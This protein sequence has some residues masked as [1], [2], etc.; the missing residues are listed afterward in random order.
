MCTG[1]DLFAFE[2]ITKDVDNDVD[3]YG[4]DKEFD[5]DDDGYEY[6]FSFFF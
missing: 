4:N 1:E 5:D 3:S 6:S 2:E